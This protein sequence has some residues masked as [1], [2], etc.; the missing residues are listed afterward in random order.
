MYIFAQSHSANSRVILRTPSAIFHL[1]QPLSSFVGVLILLVLALSLHLIPVERTLGAPIAAQSNTF[2]FAAGGD[3]GSNTG[4]N[5]S[6][7]AIPATGAVFFLALGD[8]DYDE[9]STDAAWCDYVKQRVGSTFPFE[10]LTGNHEEGSAAHPGPDGYIGNHAACLPDRLSSRPLLAGRPGYPANYYFD[11][12]RSNPL[13]RVIMISAD[14]EFN[15]VI[16][17]YN[18]QEQTNYNALAAAIDQAKQSGMWVVVGMH[19]VCLTVGEKP[20]EIGADLTNLL[21]EKRVDL[22]LQGHDHNYQRSKQIALGIDCA[23][24]MPGAY[25]A[26]CIADDGSD[27]TYSRG[28]GTVFLINGNMGRCCYT[29]RTND[30]EARYFSKMVGGSGAETNGFVTYTVSPNRIDAAVISSVGSW[31][32]AFSIGGNALPPNTPDLNAPLDNASIA[33]PQ[34]TFSWTREFRAAQYELEL[35]TG[36][37]LMTFQVNEAQFRWPMPLLPN[38]YQWR[39][40]ALGQSGGMSEWS[41]PRSVTIISASNAVPSR[42]IFFDATPTLRWSRI[43]WAIEYEIQVDESSSFTN[44]LSFSAT[45][46]GNMREVTT[47]PL[48]NGLYYWRVRAKRADETWGNWSVIDSFTVEVS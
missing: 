46:L 24:V 16:Y 14:L 21:I 20:C 39:V 30:S 25:N 47:D 37:S 23:S 18:R 10:I 35:R 17:E 31:G 28:A 33:N 4:A 26:N 27:N 43:T 11:Y 22:V 34:P 6:L 7:R 15:G 5:A 42:N 29:V 45:V 32:D 12:P 2:V 9:T 48:R 13:L 38:I 8:L 1:Q 3:I 36:V 44:P 41:T 19:K 40:R